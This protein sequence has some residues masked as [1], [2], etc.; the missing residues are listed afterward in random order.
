MKTDRQLALELLSGL[1]WLRGLS[2]R[3]PELLLQHGRLLRYEANEWRQAAGEPGVGMTIIVSGAVDLYCPGRDDQMV[4]FNQIGTGASFGQVFQ[5]GH[6]WIIT[7]VCV[8]PSL[9]LGIKHNSF[10]R[11]AESDPDMN[12][13]LARLGYLNTRH[14]LKQL[15]EFMTLNARE[16][17][18]ACLLRLTRRRGAPCR[19]AIN[20]NGLAEM[21][22]VTRKTAN[23]FLREFEKNAWIE[24][25]YNHVQITDVTALQK[26][27][28][29]IEV[30][31]EAIDFNNG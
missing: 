6:P 7:A 15:T 26:I 20:Q 29:G 30:D 5:S 11:I 19:I 2:A 17:I 1:P 16:R 9:L 27:A 24:I 25:S 4:R 3:L 8:E 21:T 14:L 18:A 23:R 10:N 31:E 22:G 28:R 13:A 12:L